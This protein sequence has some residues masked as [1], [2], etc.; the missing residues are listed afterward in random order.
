MKPAFATNGS[1]TAANASKIN[2]GAASLVLMS[3]Q[4]AKDRGLKPLARIVAYE[5]AAVA[6]IDFA[7]APA[8]ACDKLL[9]K[10]NMSIN[11]IEYHEINEAFAAVALANMKLLEIDPSKVNVHGGAVALGHPIGASGA[12]IMISLMNVLRAKDATL[13]MASIC[14]G[15]GGASAII[16]ERVN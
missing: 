11:D 3:E 16:L 6:P 9:K 13:G 2:D 12:R 10:A 7:I 8:K 4:A 14:N 5:D 1:I 15:G